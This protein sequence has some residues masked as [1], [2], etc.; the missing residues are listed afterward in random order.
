MTSISEHQPEPLHRMDFRLSYGDC[1]PAG[2]VYYATYYS[3]FERVNNEWAYLAGFPS[4]RMPELW[5]VRQVARASRCE[6]LVPGQ[7]YDL[8]TCEM[9]LGRIGRTSY[10]MCFTVRSDS[11]ALRYAEGSIAFVFITL[12]QPPR[13]VPVPEGYK[14]ELRALG[15]DV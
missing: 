4:N 8:L 13:P 3:W 2:I 1:D 6:Y 12:S 15:C 9:H 14:G 5:G 11:N 7:L 10:E